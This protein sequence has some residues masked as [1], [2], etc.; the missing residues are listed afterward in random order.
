MRLI[1]WLVGSAYVVIK[2]V[3][4][5]H[6]GMVDGAAVPRVVLRLPYA[7]LVGSAQVMVDPLLGVNGIAMDGVLR[8]HGRMVGGLIVL[9]LRCCSECRRGDD[10]D[11]A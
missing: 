6:G 10:Q 3:L 8:M 5:M 4:R 1:L 2:P 11:S 7:A 9:V